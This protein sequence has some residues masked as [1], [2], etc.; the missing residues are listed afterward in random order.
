MKKT[1]EGA[2]LV[3]AHT[4]PAKPLVTLKPGGDVAELA[5]ILEE[6]GMTQTAFAARIES[7]ADTVSRW[8]NGRAKIPGSVLAYARL[9]K[10][11][12]RA[13]A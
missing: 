8:M 3:R 12:V 7:R 11:V 4:I 5:L 1:G 13:A 2:A 9:L 6:L 10:R